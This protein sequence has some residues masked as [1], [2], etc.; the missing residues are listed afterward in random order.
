MSFKERFLRLFNGIYGNDGLNMALLCLYFVMVV[1]NS[2]TGVFIFSLLEFGLIAVILFRIFSK[3]IYKRRAEN[4]KFMKWFK[5]IRKKVN[6]VYVALRDINKFR[7]RVCPGCKARLRLTKKCGK[8]TVK[9]PL[10]QT[11]FDVRII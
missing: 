5:G 9:C 4:I 7:Y 8:H 10:C 11:K 3:N 1:A 2:F 6:H